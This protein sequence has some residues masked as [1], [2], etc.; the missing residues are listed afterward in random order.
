MSIENRSGASGVI[1]ADAVAKAA[2][3]GCTLLMTAGSTMTSIP[4]VFSAMPFD[5][6]KDLSPVAAIARMHLFLVARRDFPAGDLHEFI[7][8]LRRNPGCVSY[9][10]AGRGTGL[11]LACEMFQGQAGVAAVHVPY[12]GAS[13]ALQGLLAGQIDFYFDPGIALAHAKAGRLKL[14]AIAAPERS[15]RCP[16]LPSLAE[17]GLA[18][19]DAGT[20]HGLYAPAST[21]RAI[22]ERI[23]HEVNAALVLPE[24]RS[25]ITAL[26]ADPTPTTP[27]LFAVIQRQDR[28]RYGAVVRER[29]IAAT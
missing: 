26:A 12:R 18:G 4:H 27:A 3:D 29:H 23:N 16:D 7:A 13:A 15:P 22:V 8:Y 10:S 19:F 1:G 6:V 21:P 11:H 17:A 24:V 2:G 9:G 20:T 28:R 14:F 5:P 25:A